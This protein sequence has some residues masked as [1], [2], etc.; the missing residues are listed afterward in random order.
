MSP[1]L[2]N[3]HQNNQEIALWI[4]SF[5]VNCPF[6]KG[7]KTSKKWKQEKQKRMKQTKKKKS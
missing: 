6:K 2:G 7:K 4:S 1:K 3:S 5:G